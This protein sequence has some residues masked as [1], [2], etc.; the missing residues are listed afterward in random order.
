M[1]MMMTMPMSMTEYK[2]DF[3]ER[4]EELSFKKLADCPKIDVRLKQ[5]N[6]M[7]TQYYKTVGTYPKGLVLEQLAS[8]LLV[9][10]LKNRDVDK[11]T[12]TPF[13]IMSDSQLKRRARSQPVMQDTTLDFLNTKLHK[14][15]DSLSRKQVK[16]VEY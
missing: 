15:I 10:D 1:S 13:P 6:D 4:A 7:L 2:N 8:Y 11:V 14:Q 12:N 16:K 9:D 3:A 5:V